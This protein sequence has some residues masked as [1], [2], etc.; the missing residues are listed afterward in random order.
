MVTLLG[1]MLIGREGVPGSPEP[2][3]PTP[4][5][6]GLHR[7]ALFRVGLELTGPLPRFSSSHPVFPYLRT[8]PSLSGA[9]Q[10]GVIFKQHQ[11]Q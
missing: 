4:P 6:S 5:L 10:V 11:Q 2:S 1:A 9:G 3:L 8:L 7:A